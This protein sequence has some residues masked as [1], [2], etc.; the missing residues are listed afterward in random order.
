MNLD[1]KVVRADAAAFV[2]RMSGVKDVFT[3]DQIFSGDAGDNA[4]A[5]KRNTHIPTAGDIYVNVIPGWEIVN[6]FSN[7]KSISKHNR[8]ERITSTTAPAFILAP[9]V[10][11]QRLDKP[12]DVRIIAPTVARLLRIRSPNAAA[13]PALQLD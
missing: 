9:N 3:I 6:D 5:L 10:N 12:V 4:A 7:D 13:I 2:A 11:P 1:P 8:V